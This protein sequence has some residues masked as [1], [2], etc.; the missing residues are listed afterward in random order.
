MLQRELMIDPFLLSSATAFGLPVCRL[1][2]AARGDSALTPDDVVHAIDRG[3]NFLN[4]PGFAD[5]PGEPDGMSTAIA[6]LGDRRTSVVVCVQ[7]GARSAA[8][9]AVEL[10]SILDMLRSPY[11]DV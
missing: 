9:A 5:G 7:F 11:V 2:L 4:W 6:S 8:D 3:V 1:G 10:R